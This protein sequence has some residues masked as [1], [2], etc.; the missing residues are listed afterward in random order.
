MNVD[1]LYHNVWYMVMKAKG[2]LLVCLKVMTLFWC[3]VICSGIQTSMWTL[4]NGHHCCP[5]VIAEISTKSLTKSTRGGSDPCNLLTDIVECYQ[6]TCMSLCRTLEDWE[7]GRWGQYCKMLINSR[8][9][10][11]NLEVYLPTLMVLICDLQYY[12][13]PQDGNF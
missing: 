6:D 7:W 10:L 1:P 11:N 5:S 13:S 2:Q 4:L 8:R 3:P 9:L 12:V